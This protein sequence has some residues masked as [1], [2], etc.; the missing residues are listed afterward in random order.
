MTKPRRPPTDKAHIFHTTDREVIALVEQQAVAWPK[1]VRARTRLLKS[2]APPVPEGSKEK[3]SPMFRGAADATSFAG[4]E[5]IGDEVWN[6]S[7][8]PVGWKLD[9]QG[10]VRYLTPKLTT[11]EGMAITA[12]LVGLNA[13]R[14]PRLL[15]QLPGMPEQKMAPGPASSPNRVLV[16]YRPGLY[17]D[18][19]HLVLYVEWSPEVAPLAGVDNTIWKSIWPSRFQAIRELDAIDPVSI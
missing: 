3:R 6:R 17:W 13:R 1:W 19:S 9:K 18:P 11:P 16:T 15:K 7:K 10:H 4:F 14:P 2:I 8:V 12:K 5:A